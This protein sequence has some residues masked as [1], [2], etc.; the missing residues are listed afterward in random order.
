MCS[1]CKLDQPREMFGPSAD[2]WPSHRT[3]APCSR[4]QSQRRR[5]GLTQA[6]RAEI[7]KHQGGC[8]ICGHAEPGGKGWVVDHDRSCCPGDTSC[9]KC[10]RGV[11][12][13]W[14]NSVLGYAFDRVETLRRAIAY[15]EAHESGSNPCSW[16]MPVACAPG[17]CTYVTD[18]HE[19]TYSRGGHL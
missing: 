9:P 17:I 14:C 8:A 4:R 12:C 2:Q 10:R 18:G 7:A 13:Q 16:H 1:R 3:C 6:E 5:H 11:V 19:R 15:I